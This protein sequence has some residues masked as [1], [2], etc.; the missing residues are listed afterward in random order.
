MYE[1]DKE[2]FGSFVASLRKEKGLTQKEL[3]DRLY[4]SNKA[5]SKWETGVTIPDVSMLIPLAEALDISVTELLKCHRIEDSPLDTT[6]T[7]ELVKQV[8]GLSEQ[9]Q[10]KYRPDRWKRGLQLLMCALIGCAEIWLMLLYGYRWEEI[11][12]ALSTM[13]LL[14]ALFGGYFC[15]FVPD[16][17]PSYYDSHRI[18]T[19]SDGFFRMN[20]PGIYFNNSNWPY[21]VRSVQ[22]WAMIGLATAPA[23]YFLCRQLFPGFVSTVWT[24]V[25]LLFALGGLFIPI[26]VV[27]RKYEFAPDMSRP[28]VSR[29]RSWI[30]LCCGLLLSLILFLVP[31]FLG[32]TS[33]RS[34]T[35]IGWS[36]SKTLS[37]WNAGYSYFQGHSQRILN[38][39]NAPTTLHVEAHTE[40]GSFTLV[41]TDWDDTILYE[42]PLRDATVLDIPIPGKVTA[43][44]IGEGAKGWFYMGWA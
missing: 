13:M 36:E 19:F 32:L 24:F 14:L 5:I 12:L 38:I 10:R 31:F 15:S 7:E 4:I 1:I 27:A 34:G 44:V 6:Q 43:K 3:A 25:L 23:L 28:P 40:K 33:S 26:V 41:I 8:I 42:E 9:E 37:S 2:K 18:S 11:S 17:L 39:R 16:R 20:V 21:I 29:K 22:L 30:V 35:R